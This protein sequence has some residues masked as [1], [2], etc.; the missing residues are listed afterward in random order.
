MKLVLLGPPG[1]GKGTQAKMLSKEFKLKQISTG[2]LLREEAKKNTHLS[3]KINEILS[4]G[5]LLSDDVVFGILK[6]SLPQDNF[7]LDGFPRTTSQAKMLDN[8][9]K[10]DFVFLIDVK[11]DC[12][13][14]RV[15]NR[16]MCPKC[17]RIYNLKTNKPK[18]D[19]LCDVCG[20]P[21]VQRED[22]KEEVVRK[23]LEEYHNQTEPVLDYYAT[24][25][26]KID[27]GRPIEDVF[28]EILS[29]I[30]QA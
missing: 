4:Q 15:V 16:R 6:Q 23:R 29:K 30:K 3:K 28:K 26:I 25:V 12:I 1:S 22:D 8:L 9:I 21:L 7:I 11:D 2:D 27:G 14:E 24:R 13:I 5:K 18:N 20:L 19:N 10:P 17:G